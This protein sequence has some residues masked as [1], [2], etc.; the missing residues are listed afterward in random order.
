MGTHR[1]PQSLLA[2]F[3]RYRRYR[4]F[5]AAIT[6]DARRSGRTLTPLLRGLLKTQARDAARQVDEQEG[7]R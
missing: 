7:S 5:L 1:N 3:R 4:R 6:L 2:R